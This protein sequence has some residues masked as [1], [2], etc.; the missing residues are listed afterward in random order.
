M[1]LSDSLKSEVLKKRLC[2]VE[3]LKRKLNEV[4]RKVFEEALKDR[5]IATVHIYRA[6][7]VEG[8]S[9][10]DK[11]ISRHRRGECLCESK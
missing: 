10:H 3:L 8:H 7:R 5:S 4:D 2:G 6:L 1:G 11:V 9:I